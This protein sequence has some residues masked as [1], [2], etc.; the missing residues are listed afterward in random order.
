MPMR[1]EERDT[2]TRKLKDGRDE[3]VFEQWSCRNYH[4]IL[5]D[6]VDNDK[7]NAHG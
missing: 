1:E 7:I 5:Q 6:E 2:G 4:G 3:E